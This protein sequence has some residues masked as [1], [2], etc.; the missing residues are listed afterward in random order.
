VGTGFPKDHA[1]T[2]KK[3]GMTIRR[4]VIPFWALQAGLTKISPQ[5]KP[6]MRRFFVLADGWSPVTGEPMQSCG[7]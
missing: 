6:T 7:G 5:A 2:K 4:K 1:Q 3:N